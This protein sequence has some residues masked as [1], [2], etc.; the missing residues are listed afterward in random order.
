MVRQDEVLYSAGDGSN[1]AMAKKLE[2]LKAGGES[3]PDKKKRANQK[4]TGLVPGAN[5]TG[6]GDPDLK[7]TL[8]KDPGS[9]LLE[10][11]H[12]LKIEQ[13]KAGKQEDELWNE[14]RD[15]SREEFLDHIRKLSRD[16]A[17]IFGVED[18]GVVITKDFV[19]L[20]K[21][22]LDEDR[23]DV[24]NVPVAKLRKKIWQ[25]RESVSKKEEKLPEQIS[26]EKGKP[27]ETVSMIKKEKKSQRGRF[28]KPT[29]LDE[30]AYDDSSKSNG[31]RRV[32]DENSVPEDAK[33]AA[34]AQK[35]EKR[36]V[37]DA[38]EKERR[39]EF[40][41]FEKDGKKYLK[42]LR[43]GIDWPRYGY[44]KDQQRDLTRIELETF[45][46]EIIQEDSKFFQKSANITA[47]DMAKKIIG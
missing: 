12:D 20:A 6:S 16:K 42:N 38:L 17:A 39:F 36:M 24:K 33:D 18:D 19:G 15:M 46:R 28:R 13:G 3:K 32:Y 23:G 14:I 8:E 2:V 37:A 40:E 26:A 10:A 45:L 5:E 25:L 7:A 27:T 35:M 44:D 31:D 47:K 43:E 22:A 9:I 21:K 41:G 30:D 4:K 1:F 11:S 29:Q 34:L